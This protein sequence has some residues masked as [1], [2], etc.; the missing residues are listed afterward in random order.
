M[1]FSCLMLWLYC[2]QSVV[3]GHDQQHT[4]TSFVPQS[5]LCEQYLLHS[6][7]L[8]NLRYYLE[9]SFFP[10]FKNLSHKLLSI[11]T[12][13]NVSSPFASL[14][15]N[16]YHHLDAI[17]PSHMDP[18]PGSLTDFCFYSFPLLLMKQPERSFQICFTLENSSVVFCCF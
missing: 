11:T 8:A 12:Q 13:K 15:P 7:V 1:L 14:V 3:L 16:L 10:H 18:W 2:V 9:F 5:F 4:Q 17:L 6:G